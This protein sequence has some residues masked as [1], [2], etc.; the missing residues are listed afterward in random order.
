MKDWIISTAYYV[1]TNW[2]N[3][4]VGGAITVGLVIFLM[5]AFKLLVKKKLSKH[6][7]IYK[8]IMA[9]GSLILTLP[10]TAVIVF[11]REM[12]M[13]HFWVTY[14][15]NCLGVIVIYW[16]YENST[17]RDQLG[18]LG[19]KLFGSLLSSGGDPTSIHNAVSTA[20]KEAE[21]LLK[22]AQSSSKYKDDDLNDL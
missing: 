16:L 21:S 19:K 6:P 2:W 8:V 13:A 10:I 3:I 4:L 20:S 15:I 18:K 5:G 9:W 17:V 14:V 12:T 7:I 22:N 1:F 11:Y